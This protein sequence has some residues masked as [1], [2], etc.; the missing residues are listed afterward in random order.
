[1]SDYTAV[2]KCQKLVDSGW[3]KSTTDKRNRTYTITEKGY[4]FSK[5]CKNS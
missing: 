5:K 4:S 2:E 3:M 1:M